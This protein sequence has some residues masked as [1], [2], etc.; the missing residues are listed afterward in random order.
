MILRFVPSYRQATSVPDVHVLFFLLKSLPRSN[1]GR[2]HGIWTVS[3]TSRMARY[4]PQI[5]PMK[6]KPPATFSN[7]NMWARSASEAAVGTAA[8]AAAIKANKKTR[9]KK[10]PTNTTTEEFIPVGNVHCDVVEDLRRVVGRTVRAT[11]GSECG[12]D[13]VHRV[14]VVREG[15]P[16][17]S[18]NDEDGEGESISENE[19]C[20]TCDHHSNTS[21]EVVVGSEANKGVRW[22]SALELA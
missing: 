20:E 1:T 9:P 15:T 4:Q 16:V 21:E 5:R 7:I 11:F 8:S 2:G 10:R 17:G 13:L 22:K 18:V 12:C 6:P 3:Q 19:L 14:L